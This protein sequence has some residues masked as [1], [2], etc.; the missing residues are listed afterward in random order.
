[1]A[2][3]LG[4]LFGEFDPLESGPRELGLLDVAS[5]VSE[6]DEGGLSASRSG[7][8]FVSVF[9]EKIEKTTD[10]SASIVTCGAR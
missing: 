5:D 9:L 1:M 3:I 10:F 6:R 8:F 7:S 4:R 2:S